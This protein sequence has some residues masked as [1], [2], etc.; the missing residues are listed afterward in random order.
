MSKV[1]CISWNVRG[2]NSKFKRAS[3]FDFLKVHKP[4]ILCLQETHLMGSKVLALIKHWVLCG[5]HATYSN[6]TWGVSIL[7]R[8]GL[9]FSCERVVLD[10]KG[11]YIF[12]LYSIYGAF[13]TS[14]GICSP[15]V[16]A[17][18][19]TELSVHLLTLP[20]IATLIIGGFDSVL[21]TSLDRLKP[22]H[23]ESKWFGQWCAS[24]GM[25]TYGDRGIPWLGCT[26]V[27]PRPTVL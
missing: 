15:P 23:Y 19:F 8:K 7:I 24:M 2:L 14:S 13:T 11:Q 3:L 10:P 6:Y 27:N 4:H 1:T 18:V 22:L 20:K 25:L 12:P 9:P 16:T 17:A 21:D 26:R 5:Y